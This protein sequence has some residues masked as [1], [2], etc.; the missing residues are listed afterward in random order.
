LSTEFFFE[1]AEESGGIINEQFD[2]WGGAIALGYQLTPHV[3]L[4]LRYQYTTKD[5]DVPLR[6]YDQNRVSLDGTYSF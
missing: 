4:G 1:D 2:R 5:S 3:T 6:D